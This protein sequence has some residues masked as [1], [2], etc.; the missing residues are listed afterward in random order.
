MKKQARFSAL[1]F[2]GVLLL[3]GSAVAQSSSVP[4]P[5]QQFDA[6]STYVINYDDLTA[7]LKTV[8]VDTGRSTREVAA[9]SQARTGTRMK[10]SVKRSTASEANRFYFETFTSNEKARQL[11][12]GIQKSLEQVSD[13]VSLKYFSRDE[14]LAYWLNLYNVTV[15]N[16]IIKV[17][18]KRDLKKLLVGKKSILSKKLLTVAGIPLSLDD[19]QYTILKQNYD[20]D[21]L[22]IYGLYQGIIGGPN[23]RR[24][25]YTGADVYRALK[26]NA[27]E[28]TNS[29]RGTYSKDKKLF[30]VSSLYERNRVY[31]PDFKPDLTNHLLAYLEGYER[32]ELQRASKLKSDINDWTVTD[33]GGTHRDL[34]AVFADNNAALLN[35]VVGTTAADPAYNGPGAVMAAAVG[36]GSSSTASKGKRMSRIDPELLAK[37]H[38]INLKR[39]ITNAGNAVVTMEELGEVEVDTEIKDAKDD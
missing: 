21:P 18:P 34:G 4:E 7:V 37:L 19:I 31:F 5:F 10:V 26:N 32:N 6:E 30:R 38:D 15:L 13:E 22:I 36:A 29:N 2:C 11:L 12:S 8:V 25:A 20:N 39:E 3:T 9:P 1:I 33:L 24:R 35:A 27:I 28:F 17:Y 16:E 14:Q 23:I